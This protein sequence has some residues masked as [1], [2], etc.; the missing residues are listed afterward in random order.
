MKPSDSHETRAAL[1]RRWKFGVIAVVLATGGCVTALLLADVYLHTRVQNQAGV[2]VWGYRGSAVG[3]KKPGD[4][5]VVVVGGSTAFGYGLPWNE[6]W[7]FYLDELLNTAPTRSRYQVINL[8]APGQGAYGFSFD[9]ADYAYLRYDVAI[10]YEGYNDLGRPMAFDPT[11]G[12]VNHYLWR[13]QSPVYRMTGY[14]PV[15]PLVFREKAMALRAGGD[16]DAAYRG[17][18]HFKPGLAAATTASV[19]ASTARITDALGER[20]G[21]LTTGVALSHDP[22]DATSWAPYTDSVMAAAAG[23]RARGVRVVVVT[24]PY[25]SDAHV[26][27]QRALASAL[28][29]RFHGDNGVRYVNLGDAVNLHDRSVAYDGLHLVAGANRTIAARLVGTVREMTGNLTHHD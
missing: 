26:A 10:L 29:A 15:L 18:V 12:V 1:R 13:R 8:G 4:I 9:L 22:I 27:Q 21:S 28:E 25:V 23:A 5:R 7:P 11:P 24:Q 2:N 6:A 20:L 19:L 14:F 17:E 16:L 3:R